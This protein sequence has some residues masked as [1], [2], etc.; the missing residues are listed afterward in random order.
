VALQGGRV[1]AVLQYPSK[2]DNLTYFNYYRKSGH[3]D[4]QDYDMDDKEGQEDGTKDV[5]KAQDYHTMLDAILMSYLDLQTNGFI[6]DLCYRGKTYKDV[7]FVPFVMFVRCDTDKADVLCGSYKSRLQVL[8]N[9]V[10][11]APAQP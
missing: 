6:W 2:K 4:A 11:T 7:E 1:T 5:C 9:Y 8:H 3:V 10:L